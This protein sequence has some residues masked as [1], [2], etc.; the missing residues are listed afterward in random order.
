M[1]EGQFT[2]DAWAGALDEAPL[3]GAG[4]AVMAWA[5]DVVR[6]LF[7]ETW[8]QDHADASGSVPLMSPKHWPLSNHRSVVR[9]LG[10]ASRAALVR[11]QASV[12]AL[13]GEARKVHRSR[14][15][16]AKS[17]DHLCL[18][19]EIAA[20]AVTDGWSLN[21]EQNLLSGRKPDL[22]LH[23]NGLDYLIEI[24]QLSLDR[25]FRLAEAWTDRLVHEFFALEVRYA[26]ELVRRATEILDD[27][28]T[29]Q[30]L[31][32]VE[33]ACQ[34]TA[35]DGRHRTVAH[36]G[37]T[38]E[39]YPPG[40]RSGTSISE[41]PLVT[42][43]LWKRVAARLN[44]K[45]KQTHGGPPAWL[46][47]DD[48]GTMFHLTDWS[49]RSLPDRLADLV[50]NIGVALADAPHVRGVILTGGDDAST[51]VIEDTAWPCT[52]NPETPPRHRLAQ[53]PVAM[54][55]VLPGD[56]ER[57]TFVVPNQ[58]PHV[59]LPAGTGLEPGLWYHREQSWLDHALH[60]LGHPPLYLLLAQ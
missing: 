30:W 33:K 9:F 36:S 7:G 21:Y 15:S 45:I 53:G 26:V 4:R 5:L 6:D 11:Q 39:I 38:A 60:A 17:F 52:D 19:L 31:T 43:D 25:D 34:R 20:F 23:R 2:W 57:T 12:V 37:N 14:E 54:R 55:R 40:Q 8:L 49:A 50:H 3:T 22:W 35:N 16:V 41:G 51:S 32:D 47:I 1:R 56:R 44:D 42:G 27:E 18:T 29:E 58:H 13:L 46:R 48:I 24:T 59:L 10:L 28:A